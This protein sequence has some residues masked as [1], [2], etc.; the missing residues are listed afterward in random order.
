LNLFTCP[1][2]SVLFSLFLNSY[3]EPPLGHGHPNERLYFD[4]RVNED[5]S[6]CPDLLV[7]E[8]HDL[9]VKEIGDLEG[10]LSYYF[11]FLPDD[12]F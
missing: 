4:S 5:L 7:P 11:S 8:L 9:A 1:L 10:A 6:S 2:E 12:S 3:F